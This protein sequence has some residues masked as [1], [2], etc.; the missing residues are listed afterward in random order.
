MLDQ[1][2]IQ[3]MK[4]KLLAEKLEIE[5]KLTELAAPEKSMDNPD[6]DDLANDATEDIIE[7]STRAAFRDVLDKIN[8]ALQR[9]ADGRYGL[10]IQDGLEI[11]RDK[12]ASEPWAEYCG[13]NH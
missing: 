1:D 12:L 4:E 2:F 9:I 3:Q 13:G 11:S 10:C 8:A 5:S 6:L 7:E